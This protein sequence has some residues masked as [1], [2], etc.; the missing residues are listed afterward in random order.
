MDL[1]FNTML[2]HGNLVIDIEKCII[3]SRIATW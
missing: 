1:R 3:E 2:P